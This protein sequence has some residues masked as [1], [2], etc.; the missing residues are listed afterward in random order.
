[1]KKRHVLL[2]SAV[3]ILLV[4]PFAPAKAQPLPDDPIGG[5]L[6]CE[7]YADPPGLTSGGLGDVARYPGVQ[8]AGGVGGCPFIHGVYVCLD[9]VGVTM[10]VPNMCRIYP[11]TD[12]GGGGSTGLAPCLPGIWQTQVTPVGIHANLRIHSDPVVITT[13]CLDPQT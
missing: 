1:M 7:I 5:I 2:A 13:A 11:V 12:G 8:G 4:V 3:S 9:Y 6:G 10:T